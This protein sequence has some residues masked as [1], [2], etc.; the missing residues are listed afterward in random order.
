MEALFETLPV[1]FLLRCDGVL[2]RTDWGGLMGDFTDIAG[3][4]REELRSLREDATRFAA[5]N[6]GMAHQ[7]GLA[8]DTQSDPMVNVL[9]ESFAWLTARV[10]ADAQ[11]RLPLVS[12]SLLGLLY[13]QFVC[14]IPSVGVVECVPN[15]AGLA[16]LPNGF[17]VPAHTSLHN[18]NE[19]GDAVRWR[20]TRALTLHPATVVHA[21]VIAPAPWMPASAQN[22]PAILRL[23][24]EGLR[25]LSLTKF[26]LPSLSLHLGGDRLSTFP[27][28]E[29]V[30]DACVDV[31]LADNVDGER[32]RALSLGRK[33]LLPAGLES[34]GL[35]FPES[36][37]ALP[38]YQ[39]LQEY[40]A[41]PEHLLFWEL[42]CLER[43]HELGELA[44]FDMLLPMAV[45][46]PVNIVAALFRTCAVPV[47]NL[48]ERLAEPVRVD[49]E[50]SG[51]LLLPDLRHRDSTE[52][53]SV[54]AV[55]ALEDGERSS[56]MPY[57][58]LSGEGEKA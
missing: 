41:C 38:G 39:L 52:I 40:F 1:A 6:P 27:V 42:D 26:R 30:N 25:G 53:H 9:L 49:H 54:V 12:H 10:R 32:P 13:P 47:V 16:G 22:V 55:E 36:S 18:L 11:S 56:V 31:I 45:P 19:H 24:I 17:S 46:P 5:R 23:R 28:Y 29:W 2:C 58:S 3:L 34:D 48:F 8:S 4:Y 33:A 15:P 51:Y 50:R 7:L 21:A 14:P 57:F 20:T 35:L 44:G 43:R 37:Y